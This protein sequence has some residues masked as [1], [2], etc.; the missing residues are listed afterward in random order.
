[1]KTL[2]YKIILLVSQVLSFLNIFINIIGIGYFYFK[3]IKLTLDLPN[4]SDFIKSFIDIN[5]YF[6][7]FNILLA[8]LGCV[9]ISSSVKLLMEIYIKFAYIQIFASVLILCVFRVFFRSSFINAIDPNITEVKDKNFKIIALT[10]NTETTNEDPIALSDKFFIIQV[11]TVILNFLLI[12]VF[13][14][15]INSKLSKKDPR[16]PKIKE[17]HRIGIDNEKLQKY[18]VIEVPKTICAQAG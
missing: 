13:K 4:E 14:Y 16:K 9:S 10:T 5:Q 7:F 3:E 17:E 18:N 12:S 15:A 1:M 8:L 2:K 11:S 6:S